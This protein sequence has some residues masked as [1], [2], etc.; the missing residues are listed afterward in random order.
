VKQHSIDPVIEGGIIIVDDY[1][2]WDGCAIAVH[3]FLGARH[4]SHHLNT[5]DDAWFR[6]F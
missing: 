4:L 1:R 5:D 6:K 2:D 3:E